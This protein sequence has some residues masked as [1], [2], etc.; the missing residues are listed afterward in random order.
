MRAKQFIVRGGVRFDEL[1]R[2]TGLRMLHQPPP[3]ERVFV[4]RKPVTVRQRQRV[5][6]AGED[7]HA[8]SLYGFGG[9]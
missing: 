1:K 9:R 6:I 3:Q 2:G 4:D 5:P 8:G 7:S